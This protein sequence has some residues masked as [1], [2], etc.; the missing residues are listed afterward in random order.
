MSLPHTVITA[1][2]PKP[3]PLAMS[4]RDFCARHGISRALFYL[5]QARNEAPNV[6]IVGKRR[7]IAMEEA[8]RWREQRTAAST[9]TNN[10]KA[11]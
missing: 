5:L 10:N 3:E 9:T 2:T 7:L 8:L 6:M 11:A 4:I 1:R